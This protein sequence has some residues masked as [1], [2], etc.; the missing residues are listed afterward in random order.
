MTYRKILEL[1]TELDKSLPAP[2]EAGT[3]VA[4]IKNQQIVYRFSPEIDLGYLELLPAPWNASRSILVV[5]GNTEDGVMLGGNA[6]FDTSLRSRLRG[7]LALIKG[8]QIIIADT[9]IGLGLGEVTSE[10]TNQTVEPES[11]PLPSTPSF[12]PFSSERPAWILIVVGVLVI[13]IVAVLIIA[14]L[15]RKNSESKG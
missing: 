8:D 6:L 11:V 12:I 15:S 2:F 14:A 10:S 13:L 4:T 3:N 9:R 1:I 7:N 5:T